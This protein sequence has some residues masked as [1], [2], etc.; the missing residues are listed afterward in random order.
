MPVRAW[1]GAVGGYY[2]VH[3]DHGVVNPPGG[4]PTPCMMRAFLTGP[5][6]CGHF[7]CMQK[8][9]GGSQPTLTAHTHNRTES[10][11]LQLQPRG[12]R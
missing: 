3:F 8:H 7:G 1:K 11:Q 4:S 10:R 5:G 12:P 6:S 9:V 2:T